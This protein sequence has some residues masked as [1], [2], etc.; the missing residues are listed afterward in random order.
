MNK[1]NDKTIQEHV[2]QLSAF[3]KPIVL[4]IR[5]T[6]LDADERIQES[7]K[8][9]S[10][11]FHHRKNICGFRLAKSHVTL[12]F[13]EGA[14]LKTSDILEGNGTKARIYKVNSV[15]KIDAISL[16]KLIKESLDNGM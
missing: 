3:Q 15:D 9:G 7:I 5:D 14:S 13:M 16:T 4:A 2:N 8:W 1:I 6:V 11:V 12:L 10:I